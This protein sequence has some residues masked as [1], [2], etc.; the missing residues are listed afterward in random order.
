[1]FKHIHVYVFLKL[2]KYCKKIAVFSLLKVH[3]LGGGTM[4]S[5]LLKA[6]ALHY[7]R[8]EQRSEAY[9]ETSYETHFP[10]FIF[11]PRYYIILSTSG[12]FK[13]CTQK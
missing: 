3:F 12:I 13:S 8:P 6:W 2:K 1:M 4:M 9:K 10:M 7:H 5:E 11:K